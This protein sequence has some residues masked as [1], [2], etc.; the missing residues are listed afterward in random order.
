MTLP[1]R[2]RPRE[3]ESAKKEREDRHRKRG[4][5]K[6]KRAGGRRFFKLIEMKKGVCSTSLL[7]G[8]IE[9]ERG[10]M[11]EHPAFC[12]QLERE[13]HTSDGVLLG[14]RAPVGGYPCSGCRG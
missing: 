5:T 14:V 8:A 10:P 13:L 3:R 12:L 11:V 2:V 1:E 6:K 7:R 4:G 9:R